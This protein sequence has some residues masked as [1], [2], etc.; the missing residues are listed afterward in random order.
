AYDLSINVPGTAH[1]WSVRVDAIDGIILEKHDWTVSC[2]FG[3]CNHPRQEPNRFDFNCRNALAEKPNQIA[4][5]PATDEYTVFA[6]PVESPGH[7][8][9]SLLVGPANTTASPFGWHDTNGAAG[10]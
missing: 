9:R 10:A 8:S 6:I 2:H 5:T 7:G 4:A 1:W 3:T